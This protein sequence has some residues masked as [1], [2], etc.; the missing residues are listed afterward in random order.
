[1]TGFWKRADATFQQRRFS[2]AR[3]RVGGTFQFTNS[4][5]NKLTGAFP[6]SST[7]AVSTEQRNSAPKN[8]STG[9]IRPVHTE[10]RPSKAN[11]SSPDAYFSRFQQF[12]QPLLLR[13]LILIIIVF[14]LILIFLLLETDPNPKSRTAVDNPAV[15]DTQFHPA[16]S[17][18]LCKAAI[19]RA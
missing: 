6:H 18:Y 2:T 11:F 10:N 9:N 13:L 14:V 19:G 3:F 12:L 17:A 5:D 7:A 4:L 16:H 8:F 1:M 15:Q